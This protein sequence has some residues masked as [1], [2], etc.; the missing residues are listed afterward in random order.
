MATPKRVFAPG[1]VYHVYNRGNEK[2]SIF[3]DR[4]DYIRW[5]DRIE[6]YKEKIGI[7][8]LAYCFLPNHFHFLLL[9]PLQPV[10]LEQ[11]DGL[12]ST[13][14][15]PTFISFISNAY[16]KYFNIRY[17]HEGKLFQ[18]T[19]KA[20]LIRD[21]RYYEGVTHYIHRN[22]VKHTIV[23]NVVDW[24]FS[25]FQ[26]YTES[27]KHF[28]SLVSKDK[29]FFDLKGYQQRFLKYTQQKK[30]KEIEDYIME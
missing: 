5:I 15:I 24:P 10:G 4:K 12:I 16:A 29:L 11:P 18:G 21:D 6:L 2:M 3:R 17:K 20:K 14:R 23:K 27:Q 9:E 7:D 1:Y 8:I 30:E 26:E 19:F 28:L 22:P 13:G 25:S